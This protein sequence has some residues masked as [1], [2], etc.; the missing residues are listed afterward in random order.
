MSSLIKLLAW[1]LIES[2]R[3]GNARTATIRMTTAALCAGLA[4]VLMLGALG[5]AVTALWIF[6]LPSLG[7]VGSPLAVAVTLSI[8]AVIMAAIVWLAGRHDRSKSDLAMAPQI[9]LSE[10]TRFFS[11]HKGAVMLAALVAGMAVANGGRKP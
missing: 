4:V 7:P 5:C 1:G 9:L 3:V 2:G 11:E 10:A 6:M 8:V